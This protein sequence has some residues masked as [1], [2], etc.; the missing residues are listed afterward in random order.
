M[1]EEVR[2]ATPQVKKEGER[3]V[4]ACSCGWS[5]DAETK[6]EARNARRVHTYAVR[7]CFNCGETMGGNARLGKDGNWQHASGCDAVARQRAANRAYQR[8][9]VKVAIA[10]D[11]VLPR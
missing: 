10:Q 8:E 5:V 9:A 2:H 6:R 3:W 11:R 7:R 1:D 4:C